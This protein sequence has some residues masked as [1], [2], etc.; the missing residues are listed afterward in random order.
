VL[1]V[2][3]VVEEGIA[4]TKSIIVDVGTNT[5]VTV[6]EFSGGKVIEYWMTNFDRSVC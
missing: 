5:G 6:K 3:N 1:D 4:L 2:V